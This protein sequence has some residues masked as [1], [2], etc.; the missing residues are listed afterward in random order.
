MKY[1]LE[2]EFTLT[3]GGNFVEEVRKRLNGVVVL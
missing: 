2:F 1:P 3:L